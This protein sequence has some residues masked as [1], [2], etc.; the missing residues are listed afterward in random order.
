MMLIKVINENEDIGRIRYD[1]HNKRTVLFFFTICTLLDI[2][3]SF[4]ST[5]KCANKKIPH[6]TFCIFTA[7]LINYTRI[8]FCIF[9]FI[10]SG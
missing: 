9:V 7:V 3:L 8:R 5:N 4:L 1:L 2:N 6:V 10:C